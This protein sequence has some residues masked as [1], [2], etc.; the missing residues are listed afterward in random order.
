V[1]RVDQRTLCSTGLRVSAMGLGCMGM[2]DS[3]GPADEAE[4]ISLPSGLHLVEVAAQDR[5]DSRRRQPLRPHR[6][7]EGEPV[8]QSMEAFTLQRPFSAC[9]KAEQLDRSKAGR[10]QGIIGLGVPYPELG[11]DQGAGGER[12]PDLVLGTKVVVQGQQLGE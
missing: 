12:Q 11:I 10:P 9:R 6:R 1:T 7:M 2:S 8:Q 4:S 5:D 3:C